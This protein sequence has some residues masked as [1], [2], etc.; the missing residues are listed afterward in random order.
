MKHVA[1]QFQL[2]AFNCPHCDAYANMRWVPMTENQWT[3]SNWA[4]IKNNLHSAYCAHC[5]K[6]TIWL[7]SGNGGIMIWPIGFASAQMPHEEMPADIIPHYLEARNIATLSPR[8]AAALMRLVIQKLCIH[9]GEEGRNINDDIGSLVKKGL[10]VQ[11]QQAL[12]IVRVTG[13]NAVHPGAIVFEDQSEVA[14]T[15]FEIT[16][17]IVENRIAEPARI[18]RLYE[19]LPAGARKAIEQRDK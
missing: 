1:P 18:N 11:I 5:E 14:L 15:L 3:G 16:N 7:H 6:A 4:F 12:D 17:F 2:K 9:L 10:P 13:N 19:S 8:G